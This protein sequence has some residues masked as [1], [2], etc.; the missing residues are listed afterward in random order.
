[1]KTPIAGLHHV[2]AIASNPQR[3]LDFYTEVLGLRFV[4]KT[5][6]FD[7]PGTYHFYFG[8]DTGKPGTILTFFPWPHAKRGRLG[9]GEVAATA[10]SIPAG[11][12]PYWTDRLGKHS[13]DFAQSV[14]FG[15]PVIAFADPDGMGLELV[16]NTEAQP[17][18]A[19]R[20]SDVPAAYAVQGFYGVT[21]L[22]RRVEPTASV[23]E[24]MQ[25]KEIAREGDR[26]RFSP[27]GDALGRV[28]DLLIDRDAEPSRMG[29]G[30]VHHIA[31][32]NT[33]D[34]D[35][36]AWRETLAPMVGVTPVQERTYFRSIYF[37]EP[38]G[39]LFEMAT[40]TPGF[41]IDEPVEALGEALHIPE[42]Y[43]PQRPAIEA[44]LTP[45]TLH[46]FNRTSE[47]ESESESEAAQ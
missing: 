7:D 40:D 15:S 1:M 47:S 23:L 18:V 21:L 25:Y 16:E 34:E 27:A 22:E 3:N 42:W 24:V 6:N 43:E 4:K 38:G 33:G 41:L 20:Y 14:R 45:L 44:R 30:T 2:T 35:Q 12:L 17:G 5:V 46:K 10:F 31:F 29:A 32:R 8:D 37:R 39:V 26:V 19:P 13:V 9:A 11:S 28:V 36:L